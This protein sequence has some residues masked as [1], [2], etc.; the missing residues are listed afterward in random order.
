MGVLNKI[1]EIGAFDR[2]VVLKFNSYTEN[3]MGEKVATVDS[4]STV[5]AHIKWT[6]GGEKTEAGMETNNPDY[7]ICIR[8]NASVDEDTI[9]EYDGDDYDITFIKETGRRRFLDLH[10]TKR[11]I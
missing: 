6:R 10:A 3:S 8:Y 2:R 4:T 7:I 1:R 11:E 5:W 9:I